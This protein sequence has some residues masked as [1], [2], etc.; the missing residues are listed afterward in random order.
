MFYPEEGDSRFFRKASP[1]VTESQL[2]RP[3]DREN[4][5]SHESLRSVFIIAVITEQAGLVVI[6]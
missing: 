3:H 4:L 2:T 6:L 5:K 1:R